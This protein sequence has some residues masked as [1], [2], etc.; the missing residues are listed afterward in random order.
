MLF[1]RSLRNAVCLFTLFFLSTSFGASSANSNANAP[2]KGRFDLSVW[3]LTLPIDSD[4]EKSGVAAEV[5]P[6]PKNFQEAPYFTTGKDAAMVFQVPADGATTRGS[7]YPRSELRELTASGDEASWTTSKG[8]T[9]SATLAVNQLATATTGTSRI[10]IGQI[11]GPDDELCRLY[12]DKGVLF[13]VDDKSGPGFKET[14]FVLKS[15]AGKPTKIPLNAKF[16]YTIKATRSTLSVSA[17]HNG[18]TYSAT[19]PISNFWKDQALYFKAGVYSQVGKPG[20]GAGNTGTGYSRAS[21][22][23]ITKPSHP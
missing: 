9:M 23:N 10:V 15:S 14:K 6:I 19:E 8:G 1:N 4:G 17:V 2:S 20:S 22:Y 13:F 11:H 12:Y 18:V 5:S 16:S 21:F 7:H 3:K